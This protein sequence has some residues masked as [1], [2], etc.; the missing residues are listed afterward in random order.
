MPSD[1]PA[2]ILKARA[3]AS[4]QPDRTAL[5]FE[6]RR[7]TFAEF[8][9]RTDQIAQAFAACGLAPGERIAY[10]GRNS[11]VFYE[12][13]YGAMKAGIVMVPVNWRLAPPEVAGIVAD[14]RA[15]MVILG[16]EYASDPAYA[17]LPG[18]GTV[19]AAEGNHPTLQ[20]FAAWRDTQPATPLAHMPGPADIAVQLYTSGT[21]G[22]PKGVMLSHANIGTNLL[23]SAQHDL[24]WNRWTAD[25]R[26]LQA[27]P[28]SHISGAGIGIGALYY[29][30]TCF[31]QRQFDV[32]A[33]LDAIAQDRITKIFLVPAALQMLVRHSRAAHTDFSCL[34]EMQYGASPMPAPLLRECMA[35][36]GTRFVQ[37]YGMTETTG[38]VVALPAA[39]HDPDRP[40]RLRAAGL[41]LPWV[42]L[43]V[44]GPDGADV[45]AGTVG[46]LVTRSSGTMA[47][48]WN[49]PDETA[50][51]IAAGGWLRTGD[52]GYL[53]ADGYVFIHDRVKDM[54][55]SGGENVYPAEVESALCDHPAV[56]EAA[57]IGIP[58]AQWGEAVH[59]IVVL[60]PD[61]VVTAEA[62]TTWART[63]IAGFKAP[64]SVSFADTLPRNAAGKLLKRAL[65]E[66]FWRGQ[67]RQVH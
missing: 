32:A 39:D 49:R 53:D 41:P 26:V 9:R 35:V 16:A 63:R 67:D 28:V 46:E 19:I 18:A 66:P 6:G 36:L 13:L 62:L 47:G 51:T 44:V 45:P 40:E 5:V 55:I 22:Q 60:R 65:R 4:A 1:H 57:V 29:G 34:S 11:D 56:A 20:S 14:A 58:D 33:T 42:E 30:A 64:R 7:T 17:A 50:R 25:D 31:I 59:A 43:R 38:T 15:R 48:Y 2:L 52:A 61:R 8:D 3:Q 24:G 27:M 54:V 21:T 10:V 12:A 23:A 37:F